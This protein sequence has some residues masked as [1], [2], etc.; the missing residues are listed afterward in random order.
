[1]SEDFVRASEL[2]GDHDL[3]ERDGAEAVELVHN[4][5]ERTGEVVVYDPSANDWVHQGC[6]IVADSRT[7]VDGGEMR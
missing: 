4:R 5:D 3:V 1:M 6:W 7:S 2:R